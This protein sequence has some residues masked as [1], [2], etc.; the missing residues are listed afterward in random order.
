MKFRHGLMALVLV[1][2]TVCVSAQANASPF[3]QRSGI[4]KDDIKRSDYLAA[5]L[6]MEPDIITGT[7]RDKILK[8]Y[9]RDKN[10]KSALTT[11]I[12]AASGASAAIYENAVKAASLAQLV[13][14]ITP[15][16]RDTVIQTVRANFSRDVL[17]GA[18]PAGI[19]V[20]ESI[21]AGVNT[22]QINHRLL[23]NTLARLKIQKVQ[24]VTDLQFSR[25][26]IFARTRDGSVNL[27]KALT[28]SLQEL[29]Y[30]RGALVGSVADYDRAFANK[31][32]AEATTRVF[33]DLQSSDG[34]IPLDLKA[35]IS[36]DEFLQ[37]VLKPEDADVIV[38]LRQLALAVEK[39]DTDA[40]TVSYQAYQVNFLTMLMM[41]E[42]ATYQFEFNRGGYQYEYAF[43][44]KITKLGVVGGET[45]IR[46]QDKL[47]WSECKNQRIVNV[48]G[49]TLAAPSIAN[50]EMQS[51]CANPQARVDQSAVRA[52]IVRQ[53][54]SQMTS[55]GLKK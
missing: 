6:V 50:A 55:V 7:D 51:L 15:D 41:P 26:V 29:T 18:L 12:G 13:G 40:R 14:L 38:E 2:A 20:S 11:Q 23:A 10:F 4:A 53:L 28:D 52:H 32:L 17:G 24:R 30:S 54:A 37:I 34:L 8:L 35:A 25:L 31:R 33:L 16:E 46:D 36:S 43:N 39:L 27:V 47:T 5:V 3:S 49:G 22:E 1:L 48:F 21:L 9:G 44:L 19:E 42:N 45:L